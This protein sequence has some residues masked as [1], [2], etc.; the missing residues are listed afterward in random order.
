M[1]GDHNSRSSTELG[2]RLG[3]WIWVCEGTGEDLKLVYLFPWLNW[4][5]GSQAMFAGSGGLDNARS[6]V[7]DV[8]R[9]KFVMDWIWGAGC[10][11][12]EA[13]AG[14]LLQS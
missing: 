11:G 10:G 13:S 14:S 4:P 2:L 7:W 6:W 1:K 8:K 5:S 9:G 12:W 3:E